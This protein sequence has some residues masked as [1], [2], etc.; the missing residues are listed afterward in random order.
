MTNETNSEIQS[1]PTQITGRRGPRLAAL[2]GGGLL[3][4]VV[5]IGGLGAYWS[6]QPT[7]LDVHQEAVQ[8]F[9]DENATLKPGVMTVSAVMGVAEALL[10]KPGGY[11]RN[12]ILPPGLLMDNTPNWEFGVLTELRDSIAALRNDFSRAQTQSTEN[13]DLRE[14]EAQ[15]NFNA[16][17]WILPSTEGEY[18]RG[19]DALGRYMQALMSGTDRSARFYTRADNLNAYLQV[20]EKRLGSY[21]Q[22]LSASVGENELTAALVLHSAP[23]PDQTPWYEIDD[24]FYEARGYSWALLHTMQAL[25][26]DFADVLGDKNAQ[27]SLQQILRDLQGASLPKWS[28]IVLNG[29]GY[30]LFSNHSLVMGSYISRANAAVL[31]LRV[32]LERG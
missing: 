22:R 23:S 13:S 11:L 30:G 32:L 9:D 26:V 3:L 25:A 18:R 29:H 24:V 4:L 20:V 14:A 10:D 17:S 31:D 19:L 7:H 5:A 21:A 27:L 8:R 1:A 15:F 2:I 6:V 16:S 28:P 12:D